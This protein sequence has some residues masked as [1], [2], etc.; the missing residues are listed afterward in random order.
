MFGKRRKVETRS[1]VGARPAG[2]SKREWEARRVE[3]VSDEGEMLWEG[4]AK[5]LPREIVLRR[6][7]G[8]WVT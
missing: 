1:I 3:I 4:P 8:R 2:V 6:R 5:K 7:R